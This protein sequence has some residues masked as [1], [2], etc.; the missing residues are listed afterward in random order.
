MG[1]YHEASEANGAAILVDRA[2][3]N[4]CGIAPGSPQGG[5]NGYYGSLY[6]SHKHAFLA[7]AAAMEGRAALAMQTLEQLRGECR[8][9]D[10][11]HSLGGSFVGYTAWGPM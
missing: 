7:F 2:Y 6:F 1:R 11:A 5:Y 4:A 8:L 10:V 3:F 9:A